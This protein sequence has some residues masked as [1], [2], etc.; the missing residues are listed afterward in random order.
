VNPEDPGLANYLGAPRGRR[1][2]PVWFAVI[3]KRP[4]TVA[5]VLY[6][7]GALSAAGGWFD[8]RESL[9]RIEVA[10]EPIPMS[11]N[12]AVPDNGRVRWESVGELTDYPR[13]GGDS[14][15][16]LTDGQP[17]ELRLPRPLEVYGI[18]VLGRAGGEYASC[19][20]LAA[21]GPAS[22]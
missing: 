22:A 1:G 2:D 5:R 8:S 9:P 6:R 14:P 21:Y 15:P 13:T 7:H 19:G 18:R 10:R 20:E 4:A 17:F 12:A 11:A 3:L 16:L